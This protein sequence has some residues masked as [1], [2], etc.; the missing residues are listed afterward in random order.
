MRSERRPEA[1]QHPLPDAEIAFGGEISWCPPRSRFEARGDIGFLKYK[2]KL[3]FAAFAD[4]EPQTKLGEGSIELHRRLGF[5]R[6]KNNKIQDVGIGPGVTTIVFPRSGPSSRLS[7][8]QSLLDYIEAHGK[9]L[10]QKV[11]GQ[12]T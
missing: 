11:G 9:A 1:S 7:D 12:L 6:V 3:A 2:D 8:Q 4:F 10:F 5:E